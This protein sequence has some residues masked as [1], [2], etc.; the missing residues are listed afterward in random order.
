MQRRVVLVRVVRIVGRGDG[1]V[2]LSVKFHQ[3]LVNLRQFGD[4]VVA[5]QLK[6]VSPVQQF[7]VPRGGVE[8]ALHIA[9]G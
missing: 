1:D 9:I 3:A 4:I 2:Q 5:H 7:L 8:R 6:E